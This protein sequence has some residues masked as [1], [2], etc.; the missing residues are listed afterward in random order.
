MDEMWLDEKIFR[1]VVAHAPLVAI[2]LIVE[3][4]EGNI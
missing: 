2:D 1:C 4:K 3:D